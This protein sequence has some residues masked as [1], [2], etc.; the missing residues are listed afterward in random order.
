[1]D[2]E[3][4]KR[5]NAADTAALDKPYQPVIYAI[6]EEHWIVMMR[7]MKQMPE[8]LSASEQCR[9]QLKEMTSQAGRI[10]E[11]SSRRLTELENSLL[12]QL[13][14]SQ[15]EQLKR[16]GFWLGAGVMFLATLL[17]SLLIFL[18]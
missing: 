8:I 14:Q 18:R 1:L 9:N 11:Q 6:P 3:K 10:Q 7:L 4:L 15:S 13:Q 12:H 16:L 17:T 5:Q 2:Y